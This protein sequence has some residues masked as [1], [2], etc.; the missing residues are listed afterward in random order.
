[1]K[2]C[3]RATL[4]LFSL[5]ERRFDSREIRPFGYSGLPDTMGNSLFSVLLLFLVFASAT[6]QIAPASNNQ[7]ATPITQDD[8]DRLRVRASHLTEREVNALMT[9]AQG[10]DTPS[11]LL[12]G[13]AYQL[14][15]GGLLRDQ[16]EAQQ[17]F[18]RAA[19]QGSSIAASQIALFYDNL[20]GSGRNLDESLTWYKK[21]A[22]MGSDAVAQSN[23]GTAYEQLR[24]YREAADWYRRASL[25]GSTRAALKLAAMSNNELGLPDN[26]KK[27]GK[28]G[29]L[30]LF[31]QLATRG[32]PAGE[33]A[34]GYILRNGWLDVHRDKQ[35]GTMWLDRAAN[36]GDTQAMVILAKSYMDD[37][38]ATANQQHQAVEEFL[39]AAD[40]GE[41]DAYAAL[42]QLYETGMAVPRDLTAAYFWYRLAIDLNPSSASTGRCANCDHAHRIE[43]EL[44][45]H[46]IAEAQLRI[47]DFKYE[48]GWSIMTAPSDSDRQP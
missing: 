35:Q 15:S 34:L 48:H 26:K 37:K 3:W 1:M 12:L 5:I 39:K 2:S 9:Q 44:N 30:G 10:G 36:Q 47:D 46:Q 42:G 6:G 40:R 21:A 11:Q 17:W 18:R 19:D 23:L 14:G 28:K 13:M 32:N 25:N 8:Y 20:T 43:R 27:E 29:A 7:A 41:Y 38:S 22:E 24:Q 45:P 4:N 33:C 16:R 31:Q